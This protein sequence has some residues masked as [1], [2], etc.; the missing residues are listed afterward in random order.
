MKSLAQTIWCT[1]L[2]L[3]MLACQ[4]PKSN[5]NINS[6]FMNEVVSQPT[7]DTVEI[8]TFGA[9]CFWCVE[10]VFVDLKG[11]YKVESGY[12]GGEIKNPSYKE[13]C[14]GRTG[15]AE[16]I[17]VTFNPQQISF[18]ELLEVFF[19]THDPTT[20]NRQGADVGTQYRSSI[21]FHNSEQERLAKLAIE[22]GNQSGNW[23]SPIVTEV[24]AI[25]NFYKAEDYH[26]DYFE[27]N[28]EQ[29]YCQI[30]IAPKIDKFRK[31]FHEKL[32][33]NVH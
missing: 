26:Q 2:G 20:L 22:A 30:V 10:A 17:Q 31:K 23:S 1:L 8:A 32:K 21:F 19:S 24:V 12:S 14:T 7:S 28:Q 16:V 4:N 25:K 18:S 11:V 15:H 29:P 6:S 27:L 9:G 13:V 3:S 5:Q 33:E